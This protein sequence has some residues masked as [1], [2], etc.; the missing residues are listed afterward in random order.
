M[1]LLPLRYHIVHYH[2]TET[3]NVT[4]NLFH[5]L[6]AKVKYFKL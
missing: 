4:I 5:S 3:L 1:C 2:I 6:V